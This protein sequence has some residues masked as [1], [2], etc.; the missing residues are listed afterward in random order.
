MFLELTKFVGLGL[1][2]DVDSVE[3]RRPDL[4]RVLRGL[5]QLLHVRR[6]RLVSR[7]VAVGV[8]GTTGLIAFED[9]VTMAI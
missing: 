8:L 2:L 9:L 7:D 4:L 1:L 3:Q 5:D 6:V